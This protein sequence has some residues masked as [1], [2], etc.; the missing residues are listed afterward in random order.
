MDLS[1][2]QS[3]EMLKAAARELV[4]REY[5][6]EALVRL[7]A[8]ES[9]DRRDLWKKTTDAGWLGILVPTEFGGE[10]RFPHRCGGAIPGV[11]PRSRAGSALLHGGPGDSRHIGGRLS[12]TK[13]GNP[14]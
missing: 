5:P 12:P 6:K 2:T 9:G 8:A 3:Q 14:S 1:L 13:A 7:D 10:G 11:G 4:E